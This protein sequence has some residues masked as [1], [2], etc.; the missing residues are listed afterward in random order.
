M[1]DRINSAKLSMISMV[2]SVCLNVYTTI[3]KVSIFYQ[4][5]GKITEKVDVQVTMKPADIIV[6]VVGVEEMDGRLAKRKKGANQ[7]PNIRDSPDQKLL[8]DK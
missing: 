2:P 5:E 1:A 8:E 4:H 6:N 7:I 3:Y